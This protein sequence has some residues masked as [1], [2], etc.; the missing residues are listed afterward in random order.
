MGNYSVYRTQLPES[1]HTRACSCGTQ[2]SHWLQVEYSVTRWQHLPI[3][4][5]HLVGSTA[6]LLPS[7]SDCVPTKMLRSS[8]H[9]LHWGRWL[10]LTLW[11]VCW[12]L[13]AETCKWFRSAAVRKDLYELTVWLSTS[14]ILTSNDDLWTVKNTL[15]IV[16]VNWQI[17]SFLRKI[18]YLLAFSD[19]FV[20]SL[21]DR[22][23]GWKLL[24]T[25]ALSVSVSNQVQEAIMGWLKCVN[26]PDAVC[27]S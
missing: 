16:T 2:K 6:H 9:S 22:E 12:E 1:S 7:V 24:R 25:P 19:R 10:K 5:G 15:M 13:R 11:D 3:K 4:Y 21:E 27:G 23:A 17:G 8:M 18:H 26:G 14:T 20:V